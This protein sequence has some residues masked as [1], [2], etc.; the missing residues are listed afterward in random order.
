[1]SALERKLASAAAGAAGDRLAWDRVLKLLDQREPL[2][3]RR[4]QGLDLLSFAEQAAAS[5]WISCSFS[6]RLSQVP[7]PTFQPDEI[8]PP[9][10]SHSRRSSADMNGT[11]SPCGSL[12]GSSRRGAPPPRPA[13]GLDRRALP[14]RQTGHGLADPSDM[15]R[16]RRGPGLEAHSV[17][18]HGAKITREPG[19]DRGQARGIQTLDPFVVAKGQVLRG[20]VRERSFS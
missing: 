3:G 13:I 19:L 4:R 6:L 15:L 20:P 14:R 18:D 9:R 2:P 12:G 1:M 8:V 7:A 10:S 17:P 11:G 5:S 16:P